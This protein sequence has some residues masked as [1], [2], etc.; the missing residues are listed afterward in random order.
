MSFLA[1]YEVVLI[2]RIVFSLG[3]FYGKVLV[4]ILLELIVYVYRHMVVSLV[5]LCLAT[6]LT[7]MSLDY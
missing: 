1:L 4:S 3:N 6:Q 2:M 7:T 5:L